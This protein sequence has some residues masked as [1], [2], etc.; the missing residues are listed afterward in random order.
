MKNITSAKGKKKKCRFLSA[1]G[2]ASKKKREIYILLIIKKEDGDI[3]RTFFS[4]SQV[5][6]LTLGDSYVLDVCILF[7]RDRCKQK[8]KGSVWFV[9]ISEKRLSM[10]TNLDA[11]K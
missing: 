6:F 8:E 3:D 4:R 10:P 5:I 7:Y 9:V 1:E 2:S 11:G